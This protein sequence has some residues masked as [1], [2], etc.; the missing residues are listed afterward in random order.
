MQ[1][2]ILGVFL[3]VL[4]IG[5]VGFLY[6]LYSYT[7]DTQV[8]IK[9]YPSPLQKKIRNE[10]LSKS[11]IEGLAKSSKKSYTLPV[12]ELFMHIELFKYIPPKI[13]SYRLVID[14]VDRYS[15]FCIVQTL[16][17]FN[18][19]F[20]FSKENGAPTIFLGSKNQ[21]TLKKIMQKLK[22]YDIKSKIVE[23]W[24]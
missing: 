22:M 8:E 23:V 12:N 3:T 16:S 4:F 18:L 7:N 2:K 21:K 14:N 15:M 13:K 19:P 17:S 1:K 20:V 5:V 9:E 10:K 6:S 11:W 24:L